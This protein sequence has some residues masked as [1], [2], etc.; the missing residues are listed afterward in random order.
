MK[1]NTAAHLPVV[2]LA[3]T[4][5]S[6]MPVAI[7]LIRQLLKKHVHLFIVYSA[8]AQIVAAQETDLKITDCPI[9]TKNHLC[10]Y[11]DI[12][13]EKIDVFSLNDWYAPIASGSSA[14][15]AMVICPA[16]MATISAIAHGASNNLLTRA[17]DVMIKEKKPL[18]VVPREAPL[19][20]I[21]L[22]NL[23]KLAQCGVS[24]IPAMMTFY[25][26]PDN[27]DEMINM[28]VTRIL[29]H[30]GIVAERGYHWGK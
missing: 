13:P 28:I 18:I 15:D 21:H 24:I 19:S 17:A 4:G 22:E 20:A 7:E 5:A 30:I 14:P 8:S 26:Q 11:F 23:L 16:S 12:P 25:Q 2:T 1:N 6:A 29:S 9:E 10:A 3:M 27:I